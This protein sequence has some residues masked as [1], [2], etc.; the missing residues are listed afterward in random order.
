MDAILAGVMLGVG[1]A[2]MLT[3]ASRAVAL[4]SHGQKQL[5]AAWLVDELLSMV[6]VEGPDVYDQLYPTSGHFDAPFDDYF[7]DVYLEDIGV[8][9][10]Y[11]VTAVVSWPH[12]VETRQV[13]AQTYVAV[14]L[15]D[16]IPVRAPLEPIDRLG[17]YYDDEGF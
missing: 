3:L 2:V 14:R 8:R 17:R 1:L 5:V 9:E 4:Q 12:G 7:Y 6:L 16:P 11:R 10:P 13:S 15:G